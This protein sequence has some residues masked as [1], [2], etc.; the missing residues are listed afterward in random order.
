[1]DRVPLALGI[2]PFYCRPMVDEWDLADEARRLRSRTRTVGEYFA[3]EQ[4]LLGPLPLEPFETGRWFTPRVDRFSQI[5][6]RG[7]AYSVPVRF[8]GHQLRVLLNA[9]DLVVFDGRHEVTRHERLG[10][11]AGSRLVLDHYL[12]A[13]L[14]KPGAFPGSTPLEQARSAGRFTPVHDKWWTAAKAAHGEAV[15]TRALIEV[16]L[17]ARHMDHEQVVAGLAAAYR[18]GALTADAVALEARKLAESDS[19]L[20]LADT[21]RGLAAKEDGPTASVVFLADWRLHT[22]PVAPVVHAFLLRSDGRYAARASGSGCT[23]RAATDRAL[24]ELLQVDAQFRT[25][26]PE[27]LGV[28]HRQW[29]S[30]EAVDCLGQYLERSATGDEPPVELARLT[31]HEPLHD[32]AHRF[33]TAGTEL[34]VADLPSSVKGWHTVRVLAPRLVTHQN[35]APVGAGVTLQ[36]ALFPFAVP[37]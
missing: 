16:L 27:R 25:G 15:G 31:Q 10:G 13:L 21:K 33:H 4:H 14:R 1:M 18:A 19:E 12:E 37:M 8:I 32:L 17:L 22:E 35:E 11:R 28:G 23:L 29:S 9:N 3:Q 6:V 36:D 26:A 7:N 30:P 20:T 24:L 34:L 5:H 2:E